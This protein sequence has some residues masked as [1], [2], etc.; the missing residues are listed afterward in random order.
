MPHGVPPH[1]LDYI[2]Q[3]NEQFNT[4]NWVPLVPEHFDNPEYVISWKDRNWAKSSADTAKYLQWV[5]DDWVWRRWK[6]RNHIKNRYWHER[7]RFYRNG[8]PPYNFANAFDHFVHDILDCCH[9]LLF[10]D[11]SYASPSLHNLLKNREF[12]N[13]QYH[14][15]QQPDHYNDWNKP[16]NPFMHYYRDR[17]GRHF[18][19]VNFNKRFRNNVNPEPFTGEQS[20]LKCWQTAGYKFNH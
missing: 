13:I 9:V 16:D 20:Y 15:N 12:D 17:Q 7:D 3:V 14:D 8:A 4:C 18:E 11:S 2:D 19:R 1:I 10:I 6:V 5:Y